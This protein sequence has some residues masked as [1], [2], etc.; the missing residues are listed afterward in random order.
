VWSILFAKVPAD[1]THPR[2]NGTERFLLQVPTQI[3]MNTMKML[4][5]NG[6]PA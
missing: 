4:F 1:T 3:Q 5:M 6:S 2:L